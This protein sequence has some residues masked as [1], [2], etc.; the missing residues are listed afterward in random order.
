MLNGS[1]GW[2]NIGL[3]FGGLVLRIRFRVNVEKKDFNESVMGRAKKVL[4]CGWSMI[5]M[6]NA[7]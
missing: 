5:K 4:W 2:L 6:L 3:S 7:K 1:L